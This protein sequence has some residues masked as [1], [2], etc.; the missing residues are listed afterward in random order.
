MA[1]ENLYWT[2]RERSA[3]TFDWMLVN[4]AGKVNAATTPIMPRVMRTSAKVKAAFLLVTLF[5]FC[6]CLAV[7]EL[8]VAPSP[9]PSPVGRGRF[10]GFLF[11][12]L[13]GCC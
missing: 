11:L 12:R 10:Y 1:N 3:R 13:F 8:K 9:Q 7:A 4:S 6:N 5:G 2:L